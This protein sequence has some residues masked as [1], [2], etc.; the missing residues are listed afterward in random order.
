MAPKNETIRKIK[1][2]LM[3]DQYNL[4]A[5]FIIETNKCQYTICATK[6]NIYKTS[7]IKKH[8]SNKTKPKTNTQKTTHNK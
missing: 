5:T 3:F 8:T 1:Y 7:M 4:I 6:P 2:S